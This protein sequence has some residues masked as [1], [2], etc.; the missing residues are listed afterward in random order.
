MKTLEGDTGE[1]KRLLVGGGNIVNWV[2]SW[3]D[4]RGRATEKTQG[5]ERKANG[6]RT[7]GMER[8]NNTVNG[9]MEG[10]LGIY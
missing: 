7:E 3:G 6:H 5:K 4:G 8:D 10:K 1:K 2:W 9:R